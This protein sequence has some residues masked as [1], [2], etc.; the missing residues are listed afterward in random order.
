M[1]DQFTQVTCNNRTDQWGGSIENRS[2]FA[3]EVAKAVSA[4]I[5]PERTAIRLSPYGEYQ[6]MK[7]KDL[8]PQ[9]THLISQLSELKLAYLHMT[10]PRVNGPIDVKNPVDNMGWAV[11]AWNGV[12]PVILA[13]GYTSDIAIDEVD[14]RFSEYD[15]LIAFG[16]YFISTPDLPYR[17]QS[18]LK[19]TKY[20]RSTFYTPFS[21]KGYTDYV[22]SDEWMQSQSKL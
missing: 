21:E 7:M 15:I 16:R 22:F 2:R 11:A 20:D 14:N 6:A 8:V 18:N 17:V 5:G 19:L 1:V 9:Y 4:A 3:L 13:G 10:T 12:S